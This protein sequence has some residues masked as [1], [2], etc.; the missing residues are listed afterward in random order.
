MTNYQ[1]QEKQNRKLIT[2]KDQVIK[3]SESERETD[4]KKYK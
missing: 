3:I 2:A 4:E 1:S